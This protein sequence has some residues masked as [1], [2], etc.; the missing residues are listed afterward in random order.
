VIAEALL[1]CSLLGLVSST[2][3]LALIAVAASRFRARR[4]ARVHL[5]NTRSGPPVSVL[6]PIYGAEPRLQECLESFFSLQYRDFEIV[7]AARDLEDPAWDVVNALRRKYPGVR[8]QT[9]VCGEPVHPNAKVSAL[10][11]MVASAS[12]PF[13]VISDSDAR[14]SPDCLTRLVEPLLDPAVGLVTCLYRGVSTGGL[15]ARL[16]AQAMSVEMPSGVLVADM[17]EGMRFALGPAIATRQDVIQM[18][19]GIGVLG[20]YCAD[21][22]VLGHLVHAAGKVVILSDEVIDHVIVNRSVADSLLHQMRWMR[23]TRFSRTWGHVG[24]G[25]TFAMPF[26]VLGLLAAGADGRWALGA[27]L[28]S[29]AAANRIAQCLLV[30]WR[31]L[32]DDDALMWCW[33]YPVRDLLGFFIWCGSFLGA[34]IVWRGERY[35]LMP[36]GL[37]R[38]LK[39]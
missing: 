19:G 31:T 27:L 39:S 25:L 35:E 13:L 10:E 24:T 34:H 23:S 38:A 29:W 2:V 3:Y 30:G 21:D 28:V 4:S 17:L 8:T 22:Y 36:G 9:I 18:I 15:C 12:F 26:G 32:G 5:A 7:F 33:L 20:S 6:K 16:E 11:R 1:A 14:V 37:M